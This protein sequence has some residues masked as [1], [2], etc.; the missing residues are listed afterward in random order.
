MMSAIGKWMVDESADRG[1]QFLPQDG[2]VHVRITE[3]SHD[4]C[5]LNELRHVVATKDD[6]SIVSNAILILAGEIT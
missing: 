2:C 3:Q 1:I 4:G 5:V 6:W